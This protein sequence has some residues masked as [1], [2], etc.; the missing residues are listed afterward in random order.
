VSVK[1]QTV[2]LSA[3]TVVVV[4]PFDALGFFPLLPP[5]AATTP[6]AIPAI[7]TTATEIATAFCCV[8]SLASLDFAEPPPVSARSLLPLECPGILRPYLLERNEW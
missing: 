3:A 6:T 4:E 8:L 5:V 1:G 7:T 2:A